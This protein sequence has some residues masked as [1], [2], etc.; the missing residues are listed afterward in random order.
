[1]ANKN[2]LLKH[3]LNAKSVKVQHDVPQQITS[4]VPQKRG[5]HFSVWSENCIK[6][7]K[8]KCFHFLG[9]GNVMSIQFS[10]HFY[11]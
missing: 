2:H 4:Y 7:T 11:S 1:M 3:G 10:D 6:I 5:F 9:D 8:I